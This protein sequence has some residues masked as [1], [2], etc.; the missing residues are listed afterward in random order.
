[1]SDSKECYIV[2]SRRSVLPH[3]FKVIT[4]IIRDHLLT[5]ART[6]TFFHCRFTITTCQVRERDSRSVASEKLN[7]LPSTAT[8][9]TDLGASR[10]GG[11]PYYARQATRVLGTR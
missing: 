4:S 6:T 8:T 3:V 2:Y 11:W 1:M 5:V 7:V 10:A 9:A